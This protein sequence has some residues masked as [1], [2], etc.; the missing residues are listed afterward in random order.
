MFKVNHNWAYIQARKSTR[1]ATFK[2][3]YPF[4]LR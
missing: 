1:W 4:L 3:D 2:V